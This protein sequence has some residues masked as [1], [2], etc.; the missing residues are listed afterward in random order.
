M[1]ISPGTRSIDFQ[2]RRI[3]QTL[4]STYQSSAI[5]PPFENK[6]HPPQSEKGQQSKQSKQSKQSSKANCQSLLPRIKSER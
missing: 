3:K 4:P 6:D 2:S 5:D 1:M